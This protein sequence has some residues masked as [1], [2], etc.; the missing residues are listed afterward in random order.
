MGVRRGSNRRGEREGCRLPGPG[1]RGQSAAS[2]RAPGCA[3]GAAGGGRMGGRCFAR[4]APE[5]E[6]EAVEKSVVRRV[7]PV[8]PEHVIVGPEEPVQGSPTRVLQ[9]HQKGPDAR[10]R[11]QSGAYCIQ[12]A[13]GSAS[14]RNRGSASQL[15]TH[16]NYHLFDRNARLRQVPCRPQ[17]RNL[18]LS[19]PLPSAREPPKSAADKRCRR[20]PG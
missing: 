9:R 20:G 11:T 4:C 1:R 14:H 10:V 15:R 8:A 6:D 17:N 16:S 7:H 12:F 19:R 18:P 5:L 3:A 2:V 13:F